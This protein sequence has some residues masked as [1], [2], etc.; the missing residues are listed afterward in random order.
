MHAQHPGY[1]HAQTA[2]MPFV[3]AAR[4]APGARLRNAQTYVLAAILVVCTGIAGL[5]AWQVAAPRAEIVGG[6]ADLLAAAPAVGLGYVYRA[7]DGAEISGSLVVTADGHATGTVA[8]GGAAGLAALAAT[9]D[10]LAV[11]GDADWWLRRAPDRVTG[12]QDRWVQPDGGEVFPFDATTAL[13]PVALADLVREVAA[14]AEVVG[15]DEIADGVPVATMVSGDWTLRLARETPPR[16]VSLNGPIGDDG[17]EPSLGGGGSAIVPVG[18]AGNARR[19]A[20]GGAGTLTLEAPAPANAPAASATT[21]DSSAALA[22]DG[23]TPPG[24]TASP[25]APTGTAPPGVGELPPVPQPVF[26]TK[27]NA[28]PCSSKVCSW[29]VSAGNVGTAAGSGYLITGAAPVM[30]PTQLPIAMLAPGATTEF[31]F[32]AGNPAPPGGSITVNFTAMVFCKELYGSD[33]KPYEKLVKRGVDPAKTNV[34]KFDKAYQRAGIDA[35]NKMLDEG[36]SPEQT[37][38][39]MEQAEEHRMLPEVKALAENPRFKGLGDIAKSLAA[40]ETAAQIARVVETVDVITELLTQSPDAKVT[41]VPKTKGAGDARTLE[42]KSPAGTTVQVLTSAPG[43]GLPETLNK[44][45]ELLEPQETEKK[46]VTRITVEPKRGDAGSP[47]QKSRPILQRLLQEA[48]D[49]ILGCLNGGGEGFD[50]LIVTN[51]SGTYAFT[52]SEVCS[53]DHDPEKVAALNE[54][55]AG[56]DALTDELVNKGLI[57]VDENGQVT[58]VER[59]KDDDKCKSS[60]TPGPLAAAPADSM[61]RTLRATGSSAYLCK[62]LAKGQKPQADPWSWPTGKNPKVAGTGYIFQRCHLVGRQLGGSGAAENLVTC[63][64]NPTN[65]PEMSGFEAEVA[66]H[67]KGGEHIVYIVVPIYGGTETRTLADNTTETVTDALS[68][69]EMLAVG[70]RGTFL[71]VTIRNLLK[72][73]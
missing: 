34:G 35:M 71:A 6:A 12:V 42:I 11:Y 44:A 17:L 56:H 50:E 20:E 15:D 43:S 62:P 2:P 31:P 30:A 16:I 48:N 1:P 51:N 22:G 26:T 40:A 58:G 33:P 14:G 57:F 70:D 36:A 61:G 67:V 5:T 4:V 55:L 46:K 63:Y 23:A 21:T 7:A 28:S 49:Q 52:W 18:Y 27:I 41:L 45:D 72:G 64:G 29:S 19:F 13:N 3:P 59:R 65:S 60:Y 25:D 32:S 37:L 9:P 24:M 47:W 38:D 66:G 69:I 53:P 68:G 73:R 10:G 39:A 8:D 54:F